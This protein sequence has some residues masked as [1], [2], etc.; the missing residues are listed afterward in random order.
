MLL[1]HPG[2][3][4]ISNMKKIVFMGSKDIG[5][6]CLEQL[7]YQEKQLGYELIGVLTN[8]RGRKV[9][10]F[11]N[12]HNIRI[13]HDL[14]EYLAIG[15]CDIAISVQYHEILKLEHI[16][17]A[18]EIIVNLHMAPLPEYRGCNQFSFAIIDGQAEFGTTLHRLEEG[19]DTGAI[20]CERRFPIPPNCWVDDLYRITFDESVKLFKQV[21]PDLVSGSY[22]LTP[23]ELFLNKRA[24][25]CHSRREIEEIKQIDLDWT[26]DKIEKH[27]RATSMPGFEPPYTIVNN[28]RIHFNTV[29]V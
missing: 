13:I 12:E 27:V 2:T 25:S 18:K 7:V 5:Y 4:E 21:L 19:V 16:E 15:T 28:K 23:Q 20:I 24:T 10:D 6:E 26:K 17:N 14:D 22:H 11:C 9:A 1:N 3:K 29:H 8:K